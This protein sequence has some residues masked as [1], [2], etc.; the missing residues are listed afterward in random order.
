MARGAQ[1][2]GMATV[3]EMPASELA[4]KDDSTWKHVPVDSRYFPKVAVVLG[5]V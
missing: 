2:V 4:L 5:D 1:L 3:M